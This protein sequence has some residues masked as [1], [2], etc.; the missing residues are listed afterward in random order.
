MLATPRDDVLTLLRAV[1]VELP[2]KTTL[3][4]EVL[5]KR[6]GRAL[7]AA[8]YIEDAIEPGH[9][10]LDI[11]ELKLWP[12]EEKLQEATRRGN[13]IESIQNSIRGSQ[14]PELYVDPLKDVRQTV[15]SIGANH[16]NGVTMFSLQD[17]EQISVVFIRVSTAI[18][19][20]FAHFSELRSSSSKS[21]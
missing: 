2:P 14:V 17:K 5:E 20:V 16:D 10:H 21:S 1:G 11:Q 13:V 9:T 7:D 6:L 18:R 19:D 12:K 8:Q 15:M 3:T 4:T